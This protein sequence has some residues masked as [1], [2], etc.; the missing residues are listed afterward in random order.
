MNALTKSHHAVTLAPLPQLD[1]LIETCGGWTECTSWE[2]AEDFGDVLTPSQCA[3]AAA[4]H[5]TVDLAVYVPIE[6][7]AA[8]YSTF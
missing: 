3:I 5:G 7:P 6:R 2:V 1:A 4:L 8:E